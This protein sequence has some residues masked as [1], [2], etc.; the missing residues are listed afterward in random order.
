M[1]EEVLSFEVTN[2]EAA[3][4]KRLVG[5]AK[6]DVQVTFA[7]LDDLAAAE[8][9]WEAGRWLPPPPFLPGAE[10]KVGDPARAFERMAALER[11]ARRQ[12]RQPDG[13]LPL[14]TQRGINQRALASWVIDWRGSAMVANGKP[15]AYSDAAARE[16]LERHKVLRTWLMQELSRAAEDQAA[17]NI[18][19][20]EDAPLSFAGSLATGGGSTQGLES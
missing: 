2:E 7:S 9:A 10:F 8:Q 18:A 20:G 14:A 13:P 4:L 12:M 19:V 16:L 1:A 17:G 3:E 6:R 11:E 5:Q 15:L